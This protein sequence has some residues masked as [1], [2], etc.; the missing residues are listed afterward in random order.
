MAS[1]LLPSPRHCALF[2][3]Q[4]TISNYFKPKGMRALFFMG[5]IFL[6]CRGVALASRNDEVVQRNAMELTRELPW[7]RTAK[8]DEEGKEGGGGGVGLI[9]L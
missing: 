8:H 5:G 1:E 7:P 2:G 9:S 3:A 6:P 4:R